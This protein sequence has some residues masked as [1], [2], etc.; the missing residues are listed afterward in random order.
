MRLAR[1][2]AII[3]LGVTLVTTVACSS[4]Q[5]QNPTPTP[6]STTPILWTAVRGT[7][8]PCDTIDITFPNADTPC[9]PLP[10][11]PAPTCCDMALGTISYRLSG[12]DDWSLWQTITNCTGHVTI[13]GLVGG[14]LYD[15]RVDYGNSNPQ[16]ITGIQLYPCPTPTPTPIPSPTPSTTSTPTPSYTYSYHWYTGPW[17]ACSATCGGGVQTRPVFCTRTE[18]VEV[19]PD[20]LCPSSKPATSQACNMQACPTPTPT[21]TPEPTTQVPTHQ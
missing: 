9:T 21:P 4:D 3:L 5:E 17:G 13:T 12:A 18:F 20:E 1:I 11:G 19:V 6:T 2:A 14:G 8:E 10:G 15:V 7:D 16:I